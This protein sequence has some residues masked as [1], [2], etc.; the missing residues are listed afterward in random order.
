MKTMKIRLLDAASLGL[1]DYKNGDV[2]KVKHYYTNESDWWDNYGSCILLEDEYE[3]KENVYWERV[4]E[5]DIQ[6]F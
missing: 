4:T 5:G 6:E 1:H 3:C 2:I